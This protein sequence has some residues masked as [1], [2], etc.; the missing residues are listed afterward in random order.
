M[1]QPWKDYAIDVNVTSALKNLDHPSVVVSYG[2]YDLGSDLF[3][4]ISE[5]V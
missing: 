4:D 2:L 5:S 1:A 3:I